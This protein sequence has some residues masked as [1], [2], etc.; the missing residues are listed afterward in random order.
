MSYLDGDIIDLT[1]T[2]RLV[3]HVD[4]DYRADD[5]DESIREEVQT[6]IDEEEVYGVEL[7][8]LQTW[9][10]LAPDGSLTGIDR[11]EWEHYTESIWGCFLDENYTPETVAKEYW[12]I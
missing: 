6:L 3:V 10:L 5:V 4:Y 9:A 2:T 7:Q 12:G 11:E 1:P 8:T